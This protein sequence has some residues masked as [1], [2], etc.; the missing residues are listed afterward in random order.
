M[1]AQQ[2]ASDSLWRSATSLLRTCLLPLGLLWGLF[3][4]SPVYA[5]E[6]GQEYAESYAEETTGNCTPPDGAAERIYWGDLHTHT[7]LSMDAYVLNTKQTPEDA[8]VFAKGG[9][10]I[11][12]DGSEHRLARPLDFAAVT[13]HAE[14]FGL[15]QVCLT[16]PDRPYCKTLAE[17]AAE[18]SRRGFV[19]I[20]LPLIVSGQRN[21][22]VSDEA[23]DI[24]ER[25]LWQRTIAAANAA[26]EP[27]RF[28]AFVANEWTASPT[29]LHW[30]RNLIYAT[31]RVPQRALNSLDQP[32]QEALWQGLDAQCREEDGCEVLAIPHNSNIGMGGAFQTGG[33]AGATFALRARFEKLVE[34]HQHKGSSECYAQSNFSDEAC[35]FEFMIPIP[36][37]NALAKTPR[38][39]TEAEHQQVASGYVRD[40]LAKGLTLR[41]DSGVNPFRYGFVGATDSHSGR[42]GDV[43]ENNWAGALGQWDLTEERRR[44]FTTYN[45]GGI[46]GIWARENTRASLFAAL[47]KRQVFATSGPR[48]S[49]RFE[50]SFSPSKRCELPGKNVVPMGGT[51]EHKGKYSGGGKRNSKRLP[52]FTVRALKDNTALARIDII[53]LA[54]VDGEIEQTV[55]SV[56]GDKKGR[57]DWCVAWQDKSYKARQ[58]A[59]WYARVLEAESVRWDGETKIRERAWSSPIW[60]LPVTAGN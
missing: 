17:A 19:D 6:Y 47:K 50:Q 51:I 41:E 9:V 56:A 12:Q 10:S 14:Y 34:I 53:K 30:H 54:L 60:A 20:F 39:L 49:L 29:N 3:L 11:L 22:L 59:L 23:C 40:A 15:S 28:T 16:E 33:H 21:C 7:S 38:D 42:P 24:A 35:D 2:L 45:P 27:C 37:R 52:T 25:S 31:D 32:T 58:P 13:D 36:L 4:T 5:Q 57:A 18:N 48:I 43:D 26:N 55:H 46:T 8:Y 44:Q 1:S